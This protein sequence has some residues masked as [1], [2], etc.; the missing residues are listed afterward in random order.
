MISINNKTLKNILEEIDSDLDSIRYFSS[1]WHRIVNF[2][3]NNTGLSIAKVAKAGSI[4]KL[5][6][7]SDSDLDVIFCTSEDWNLQ[8]MLNFL[9][10][11]AYKNFDKIANIKQSTHA[12]QIDF[13]N[14]ACDIDLV[15]K[16]KNSFDKEYKEIKNYRKTKGIQQN[17]IKIAKFAFYNIV[18]DDIHGYEVEKACLQFQP[19]NLRE[20]VQSIIKYFRGR[21]NKLGFS[22]DDINEFLS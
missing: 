16:T 14:P 6:S 13:V 12:I 17:A 1:K 21:L 9:E 2:L 15:Y 18:G 22:I 7:T 19:S 8:N 5:T 4:G 20:L 11:K 3:Y 10:E